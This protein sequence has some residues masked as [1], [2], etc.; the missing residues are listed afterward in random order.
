[1][2]RGAWVGIVLSLLGL[3]VGISTEA[4]QA[5]SSLDT[6]VLDNEVTEEGA[7]EEG[8]VE[9]ASPEERPEE[10]PPEEEDIP[11][12][13]DI[14]EKVPRPYAPLRSPATCPEDLETLTGLIIRDIP[15]YTNRVLQRSV[16]ALPGND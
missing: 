5:A 13:E 9:E 14:E 3:L 7:V 2:R 8:A 4:A 12:A 16:A 10:A 1:M 11:E 6:Q 15:H